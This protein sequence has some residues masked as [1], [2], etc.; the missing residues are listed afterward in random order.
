MGAPMRITGARIALGPTEAARCDLWIRNGRVF[1]EASAESERCLDLSG[2]LLLPGLINAHDHLEF[3]LYPLLKNR[4]YDN[5][6]DWAEDIYRPS[7][8]PVREQLRLSKRCR[9]LW[10]GLKNLLSGVTTVAHHN[11]FDA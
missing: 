10:G 11:A 7:E 8:S 5:A 1:F 9:L 6:R 4:E 2:Y 3:N